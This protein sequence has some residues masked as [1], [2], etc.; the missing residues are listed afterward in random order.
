LPFIDIHSVRP[1]Q[2]FPGCRIRTPHG[3]NLMLSYVEIDEGAN[4]PA[5]HHPHEQAG[6]VISGRL[7]FTIGEETRTVEAGAMF[8]IPPDTLHGV[9]NVG[10]G[11]AL[12]LDVFSPVRED[13]AA[14]ANRYVPTP[15]SPA[16]PN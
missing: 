3:Q 5:H 7:E 12:V 8:L 6:M 15:D 2:L 13:Y 4:V 11:P 14:M 16:R 10:P 9:K 1:M